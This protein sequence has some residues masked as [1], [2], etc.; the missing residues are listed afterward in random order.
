MQFPSVESL[1]EKIHYSSVLATALVSFSVRPGNCFNE[2]C[3][4]DS[5]LC[6]PFLGM[7][8]DNKMARS[9]QTRQGIMATSGKSCNFI[10]PAAPAH[11]QPEAKRLSRHLPCL[12]LGKAPI[13]PLEPGE[14]SPIVLHGGG[15]P[16]LLLERRHRDGGTGRQGRPGPAFS[17]PGAQCRKL[18]PPRG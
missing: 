7:G 11:H 5:T 4:R 17:R 10:P 15:S 3:F 6:G 13:P 9:A 8:G 14:S 16:L 1:L 18:H 12:I 2:V